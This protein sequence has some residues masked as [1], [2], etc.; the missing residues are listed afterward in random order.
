M[1]KIVSLLLML[2]LF[3]GCTQ[4][5]TSVKTP[6][7]TPLVTYE[8]NETDDTDVVFTSSKTSKKLHLKGTQILNS[9]NKVIQLKGLSTHGLSWYP[10]YVNKSTFSKLKSDFK[11]NTIRLAMYTEEYN[12]YCSGNASNRKKLKNLID[13]AVKYTKELNMYVII[14]WHI[15]SDGNPNKH[16]S[17]A[18]SFF[19]EMAKKYK[20][21]DHIIYEICNEPNGTSWSQIKKYANK[22]IP[23]IRKYKKDA[24]VIVGTP[25]WSQDVDKVSK[26]SDKYTLYALHFYAGTHKQSLRNKLN[27]A[28]KKKI[29]VFV[30]EFGMCNADGRGAI[31]KSE[32]KKWL[33][34]LDKNKIS[35][36]AWNIS[37]KNET[38]AILKSSCKKTSGFKSSDY[39]NSGK[40]LKDYFSNKKTTT[41]TKPTQPSKPSQ[42]SKPVTPTKAKVT[43]K[44]V[45]QWYENKNKMTQ[46]NVSAKNN[47]KAKSKWTIK[48]TFNQTFKVSQYWNF[49]YKISGKTLI[50]TPVSYNKKVK[51][52]ATVKDLGMI[53][54]SK[55]GLKVV[56]TS[57]S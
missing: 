24:L 26:L 3:V 18:K 55:N 23:A 31:N 53:I 22:V 13:K 40:W 57:F 2:T 47:N 17:A 14:D 15:L 50:L 27:T 38:C 19:S 1:K 21:E 7:N 5:Q 6:T 25:T 20:K 8:K 35:Y 33:T 51:A 39:S 29:P 48:I 37:N 43:A 12:G 46:W 36:V 45:N 52:N 11:I 9:Q 49:K 54:K 28:L 41:P 34:L 30:S 44:C 4:S 32:A 42:P 10:Q 16:V 56:S